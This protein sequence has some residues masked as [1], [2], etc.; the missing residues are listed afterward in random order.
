[1]ASGSGRPNVVI[2]GAGFGGMEC[3]G[4]LKN[5]PVEAHIYDRHNYHLFTPFL[6][7]VA[8]SLM[9]PADIAYPIHKA[10]STQANGHFHHH[11]VVSVDLDG[12]SLQTREGRQVDF[13]YLVLSL[14]MQPNFFGNEEIPKVA[15]PLGTMTHAIRLRNHILKCLEAAIH[16]NDRAE[17]ER[18]LTFVVVGGGQT[19]SEFAGALAEL[20]RQAVPGEYCELDPN[21]IRIIVV[22][23]SD[24]LLHTMSP[25]TSKWAKHHL[26]SLGVEVRLGHLVTEATD[27]VITLDTGEE[28][29]AHTLVWG[30]GVKVAS[31]A[32][33]LPGV[34]TEKGGRIETNDR[35]ELVGHEGRGIY[36]IGDISSFTWR[37]KQLPAVATPAIQ[38]GAHVAKN[39]VASVTDGASA[40]TS[41]EYLDK[42][43]MAAIGRWAAAA[44]TGP[45]K[46]YGL[47]GWWTWA[48]VHIYYLA[49]FRRRIGVLSGWFWS[50]FRQDRPIQVQLEEQLALEIPAEEGAAEHV[51]TTRQ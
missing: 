49:G 9:Q 5:H 12:K 1:M 46:L 24:R 14:G 44:E 22:E 33:K 18:N 13:D 47:M 30:A 35:L 37:Q 3:L 45:V 41:F 26:E 11:E 17:A 51:G 19:G 6:Y 15:F 43:Q 48:V 21:L 50:F 16:A 23:G 34:V 10:T 20:T 42:G 7:Q 28:I 38:E 2:V 4:K 8:T 39:I 29:N 25:R 36:V 27:S 32:E 40:Q 31:L